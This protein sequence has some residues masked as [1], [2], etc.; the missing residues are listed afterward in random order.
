[1]EIR[2]IAEGP[3]DKDV[4]KAI[5]R[6]ITGAESEDIITILPSDTVD[7]TDRFSGNFSN[8]QLV[9]DKLAD[10]DFW[11]NAMATIADDYIVAVH[12]DTAERGEQGYDVPQPLRSKDLDWQQYAT[13]LRQNVKDKLQHL[14]PDHYQ[15]RIA[16]AI[17]IEETEAWILPMFENVQVDS[18]S[19]VQPKE[20]LQRVVGSDKKLHKQFVDTAKKELD[21]VRLGRELARDLKNCRKKNHSLHVFCLDLENLMNK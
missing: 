20:R 14:I 18:A 10:A 3:A 16:Y 7:E 4:I 19:H 6:K 12:I 21:Y 15:D 17:A 9:L 2:I 5:L 8:W 1:M 11:E 13:K